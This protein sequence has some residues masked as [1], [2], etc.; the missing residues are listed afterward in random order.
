M[1][2]LTILSILKIEFHISFWVYKM[3]SERIPKQTF[4]K[5][6]KKLDTFINTYMRCFT[7]KETLRIM[8]YTNF[9]RFAS[10]LARGPLAVLCTITFPF[11][12]IYAPWHD[13]PLVFK[14]PEY[15][16][17]Y[18]V[19]K[20]GFTAAILRMDFRYKNNIYLKYKD[21]MQLTKQQVEEL[22]AEE[23]EIPKLEDK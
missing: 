15:V 16:I 22:E 5:K 4:A 20:Q 18:A 8:R 12:M 7:P 21:E 14:I 11:H 23:R 3:G 2:T 17:T 6:L 19:L 13:L 1:R 10:S 9:L